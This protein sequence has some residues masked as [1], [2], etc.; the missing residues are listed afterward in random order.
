VMWQGP[1]DAAAAEA[2]GLYLGRHDDAGPLKQ[3][4]AIARDRIATAPAAQ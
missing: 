2:I 3:N 1:T 4:A